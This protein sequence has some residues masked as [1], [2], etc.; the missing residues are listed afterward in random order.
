MRSLFDDL[1]LAI[2]TLTKTPGTT[3]VALLSLG[4]GV[5]A[6]TTVYTWT[7]RFVLHPLPVVAQV[8]RLVWLQTVRH[9][10][11]RLLISYP[12]YRDWAERNR[13]FDGL[14]I[15]SL[16]Q[17]G[18]RERDG[19]GAERAWGLMASGN[20]FDILGSRAQ[21]GRTFLAGEEDRAAQVVVL[22]HDFWSRR[23]GADPSI[24][25]RPI[26][27]NGQTFEVIGVM[28][29]RFGGSYVGLNLDVYVPITTY[30]SLLG[31]GDRLQQRGSSFL[32]G[33]A[34]LKP[35]VS[36][37]A[38]REDLRRVARELDQIHPDGVNLAWIAPIDEQG[39]PTLKPVL[40]ALL[41]VTGLVLLIACAN[42]ANLLLVRAQ[43]RQR[44]IGVRLALGA[45]RRRLVR[46]LMTE[47]AVLAGGGGAIGV[48]CA[49]LG[50]R[51]MLAL[52]PPVPYPVA[53]DIEVSV[54]V[55]AFALGLATLTVFVF[56]LWPAL[57]AS[58]PDLVGVLKDS[59]TG[60][61]GRAGARSILVGAQV[62]LAVVSL[63]CA[64]LFLRALDRSRNLDPGFREPG[65]VLLVDTDLTIA[66]L[67]DTT[68]R[69]T[70]GR[71]FERVR[72]LPGVENAAA[73]SFVP[74]GWSCCSS[75]D[76][77]IEGYAPAPGETVD[78]VYSR[79]TDGYFETMGVELVAG[80][81]FRATDRAGAPSV[82]V[83]NE[84][85]ARRY[86][87]GLEPIGRRI[88]QLGAWSTVVGVARDGH[89]RT[90]T[91]TPFPLVYRT[92][93][94]S[95]D[96]SVTV[97][98]RATGDPKA[99][100]PAIRHE[101]QAVNVDLPFLDPRSMRDQMGQSTVGQEIGSRTLAL[102]GGVAL[103]LAAIGIYG[104]MAYSVS[105]RTREIGIRVAL[106]AAVGDV[107]RMVVKQGLAITGI[108]VLAGAVLALGAGR[109]LQSLLLGVSPN[110]PLTY[111]VIVA[112]LG[113]VAAVASIVPARRAAK[114]DPVVAL[115]AE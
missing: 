109:L 56:G 17:F 40:A 66:G 74:L 55:L 94:Q 76:T 80:R 53:T 100:I 34:R 101:F 99:L 110:D 82:V 42:V 41:G 35:G 11:S 73:A 98:I 108:G 37:V 85:F 8:D 72:A 63:A 77:E 44:E 49:H 78:R 83:V 87:P 114:V 36:M 52:I 2:R 28:P 25:G 115:K 4:L 84:T 51:G 59:P 62:A 18:V 38:A 90:L 27:V 111:L 7:D 86:W 91:D 103:L 93:A 50:R 29:P 60:G 64:G 48:L 97:H 104:V 10:G 21:I 19:E 106:G 69:E 30:Q 22:G 5:G 102:F 47:S 24:V 9:D 68:G 113:V 16:Q 3:A 70:M 33:V 54:R 39:P 79:V 32:E 31:G 81:G 14:G 15:K 13:V 20:Y 43:A 1:R 61:R 112:A 6:M 58:R 57:R 65:S 75:A 89:Y 96:P 45:G 105:Q 67:A 26:V 23:F 88:R 46:Q 107:T 12:L 71:L 92:W 95:F